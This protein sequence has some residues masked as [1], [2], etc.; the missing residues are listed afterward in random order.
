MNKFDFTQTES[1]LEITIHSNASVFAK[2]VL[3]I[4]AFFPILGLF[5]F[6]FRLATT[7]TVELVNTGIGFT[8]FVLISIFLGRLFLWNTFGKEIL[9]FEQGNFSRQYDYKLFKS[10]VESVVYEKM[11]ARLFL[12]EGHAKETENII[13]ED[14]VR[15]D[16]E[17][18]QLELKVE[19]GYFLSPV[20]LS[21]EDLLELIALINAFNK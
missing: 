7:D 15:G 1:K 6:I 4:L 20:N 9:V 12:E 10:E 16:R 21:K 3:G 14:W 13:D 5:G 2:T 18:G 8:I 17:K 11:I 19:E